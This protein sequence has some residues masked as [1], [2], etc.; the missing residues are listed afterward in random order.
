[1]LRAR[2]AVRHRAPFDPSQPGHASR[3]TIQLDKTRKPKLL[4]N[5][6]ASASLLEPFASIII[7]CRNASRTIGDTIASVRDQSLPPL[8]IIVVDDGSTDGSPEVAQRAGARVVRLTR[9]AYAG[10]ARNEGIEAAG[11]PGLAF[12]DADVVVAR[13]WLERV[14]AVLRSD[15]CVAGVGGRIVNGRSGVVADLEH[16]LNLSEWISNRAR[17]CSGYPTMAVAYRRDAVGTIRFPASNYGEDIF[18][19]REIEARGGSI[20]YDPLIRVEHRHER[21]DFGRFWAR[22]VHAGRA[23]YETRRSLDRPGAILVRKPVLLLLFPHLWIVVA[24]M[25]RQG[26]VVKALALLPGLL[27]G[28]IARIIGFFEARRDH[29]KSRAQSLPSMS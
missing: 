20:R 28:E 13:D 27:A 16:F 4:S 22:Q 18:F 23:F 9:R 3:L 15:P 10:G 14:S 1:L 2:F 17:T 8:E 26:H 19:G 29:D 21:L 25:L 12:V 6:R 24:R 11:G 5:D 7:P